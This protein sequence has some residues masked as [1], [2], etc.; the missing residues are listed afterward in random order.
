MESKSVVKDINVEDPSDQFQYLRDYIDCKN[1]L[2]LPEI[3]KKIVKI[4]LH[5]FIKNKIETLRSSN[6]S[7]F[8]N[9]GIE[10][11]Q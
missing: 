6:L 4:R 7:T 5:Q 10:I 2:L 8:R 9:F 3:N 11:C 1:A